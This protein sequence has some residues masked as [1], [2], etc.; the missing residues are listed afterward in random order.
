MTKLTWEAERLYEQGIDR[1]V[2]YPKVGPGEAWNGLTAVNEQVIEST[3]RFYYVDG[4]KVYMDR[5]PGEF[6]GTIEA[7]TYPDSFY[8]EVLTQKRAQGFGLSYRV[9]GGESYRIHIVYNVVTSPSNRDYDQKDPTTFSWAF[10]T[11]PVDT[12]L[13]RKSAHFIIDTRLAYS[14]TVSDLEDILYGT[15]STEPRLP[16]P[17]EIWDIVEVNSLLIVTDYGDGTF[18][19]T[20][21]DDAI[22]DLGSDT[23][24]VDWPSVVILDV[25]NYRI[26]SL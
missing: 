14:W 19:I 22:T 25:N 16:T 23:F 26:S 5:R 11:T 18:N 6:S 20:G 4:I 7:F 1:G 12:P 3:S 15:D 8:E 24:N 2:L 10:T 21:P 9:S 13:A 17:Q